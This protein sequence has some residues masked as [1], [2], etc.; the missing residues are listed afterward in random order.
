MTQRTG[1]TTGACAA[2]AAYAAGCCIDGVSVSSPVPILTPKGH[3]LKIPIHN[4]GRLPNGAFAQVEK[5]AGDD[6]DVTHGVL[7]CVTVYPQNAGGIQFIAGRGVGICTRPGLSVLPG[8]PAINPVPRQ[9]MIDALAKAN[10]HHA[11][12]EVSI[13]KGELIAANTFN[14]RL[15]IVGGLSILGTT[16]I[17]RPKCEAAIRRTIALSLSVAVAEGIT[18]LYMVPGNIGAAAARKH[19]D[20]TDQ[21][22]IEVENQWGFALDVPDVQTL[23]TIHLVGHPGKLVKLAKGQWHTHSRYGASATAAVAH[24]VRK[25]GFEANQTPNTTEDLFGSLASTHRQ[26]LG[27]YWSKK[28]THAVEKRLLSAA[29][30]GI[31]PHVRTTLV[32]L[33]GDIIAGDTGTPQK[34]S[35]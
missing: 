17:V 34:E 14:P 30:H 25:L 32:F 11:S 20:A 7:I 10:I 35:L 5:D 2:A 21:R 18:S 28:I 27:N 8:E 6:V 22:I 4:V 16:G 15:G 13:P 19:F 33:N 9:M 23:K 26:Q 3:C 1:Y 29:S 24:S 12:V 31:I